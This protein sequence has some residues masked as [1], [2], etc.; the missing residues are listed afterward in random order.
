VHLVEGEDYVSFNLDNLSEKLDYLMNNREEVDR[1][2]FNGQKKFI[3][4]YDFNLSAETL[5]K[6]IET[7]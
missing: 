3:E 1:I 5:A 6:Y 2:R 4:S 7:L